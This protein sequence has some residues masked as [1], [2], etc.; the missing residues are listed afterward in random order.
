MSYERHTWETG[1]KITADLLNNL[2]V[3]C[4][5][6][7]QL[8]VRLVSK[9]GPTNFYTDKSFDEIAEFVYNGNYNVVAVDAISSD[10]GH[11]YH[12]S[13]VTHGTYEKYGGISV[14]KFAYSSTTRVG[15]ITINSNSP[16]FAQGTNKYLT[17]S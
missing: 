16:Y 2:E 9:V 7:K 4:E 17:T 11:I 12:L 1:E 5:D 8:V 3:G 14:I 6:T 15:E 13:E 10:G